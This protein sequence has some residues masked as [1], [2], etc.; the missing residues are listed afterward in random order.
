MTQPEDHISVFEGASVQVNCNY[1]YSGSPV[2][3][4][5]VQYPKQSLRLLL[6][7]IS[8]D[9]ING[10]TADF[11][12]SGA[13]FH[14]KKSLVQEE[15]SAMY[16]CALSATVTGFTK[17]ADHKPFSCYSK[18]FIVGSLHGHSEAFSL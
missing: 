12:K 7:H 3:F 16:Y 11:N 8:K 2:L 5:Y 4:W 15:D 6:K 9:S 17:E 13:F 14:L 10:F 18:Y 1:V